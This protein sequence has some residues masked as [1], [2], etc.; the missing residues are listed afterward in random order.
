MNSMHKSL[1]IICIVY[2]TA[3]KAHEGRQPNV[4]L[5]LTDDQGYGE[6]GA[7]GNESIRT[8]HMDEL[9]HTGI[10]LTDFH[11][12]NVCSP[13]RA[14]IM[15]GKYSTS[16]GVWH[17]LGGR[18][19]LQIEEK[20]M[21][22]IFRENSYNT[23]M[24]GKWHLGD[25]Y[26]Y[27][28]EDRGFDQVFRIGGGSLGQVAD[29]WGNG[30]WDGH[31]WNGKEWIQTDGYCTDVQFEAAKDFIERSGE[32]PFFLYLATTAPHAPIGAATEYVEPYLEMGFSKEVSTFYG[33]VSNIDENLGQ[34]RSYLQE[35]GLEKNTLLIFLSDNG[36]ACAKKDSSIYNAGM[37]GKKGSD[38]D[39]GHRVP[40]F[41]YWPEGKVLGGRSVTQ[42]TAHIDL[43]PTLV[44]ACGL[45]VPENSRFDGINILPLLQ[46]NRPEWPGRVVVTEG[47]VNKR[48]KLFS[49]SCV[50]SDRWRL[51]SGTVLF[52]IQTDPGQRQA[53]NNPVIYQEMRQHYKNWH[54]EV[55]ETFENEY[56]F[57]YAD[58]LS[59]IPFVTM[60]LLPDGVNEKPKSV[61]NQA[62]V[63]KG[64]HD[65]GVWNI[66][67]PVD[68][69]YTFLLRRLPLEA[70]KVINEKGNILEI[71]IT[72]ASLEI[73][74]A[75]VATLKTINNG[76]VKI[77]ADVTKG[78]HRI[79]ANFRTD[80]A[81]S[82]SAYYLYIYREQ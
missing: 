15:T 62:A 77:K 32:K 2:C 59:S 33:M 26:P 1:L 18:N 45:T 24:I 6:V 69:S 3:C 55:S 50:I 63:R 36:S 53:L 12:N 82:F 75:Q 11:V 60:D 72:G 5:I 47:K 13:S 37:R 31:Y 35:K 51:V 8:P 39:G 23:C 9:Y 7:H 16:V 43:L 76:H 34:L 28:P 57:I 65:Q 56:W 19:L 68:G 52:D 49:S 74:G 67:F 48:E 64:V 79:S 10:R 21:A 42:L 25:N 54:A 44:E 29:Y 4:I 66:H 40:C 38:Y 73:D 71:Q 27:R 41:I 46:K 17:T 81:K 61:W 22:D 58:S 20:T 14:A 78:S 30:L 70:E 80:E